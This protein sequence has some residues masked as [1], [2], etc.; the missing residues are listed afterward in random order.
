[1]AVTDLT[2]DMLTM[3]RNASSARKN[4]VIIKSSKMLVSICEILKTEGFIEDF[5][6]MED[7]KQGQIKV[8]LKYVKNNNPAISELKR[9]S[10]PGLRK[11]IAYGEIKKVLG[12]VGISVVSTSQGIMTGTEARSKNIGGELI[13][14]AW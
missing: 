12:G 4:F 5:Q 10:T 11:Y 7:N 3:I 6:K 2:A 1:M 9:V 14:Y 13:C 8:Y